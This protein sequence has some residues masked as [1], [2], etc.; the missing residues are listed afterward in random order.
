MGY[1][2]LPARQ[3]YWVQRQPNSCLAAHWMGGQFSC[4]K[5]E[6]VW[7]NISLNLLLIDEEFE[8][9]VDVDTNGQF[10]PETEAEQFTVKIVEEDEDNNDDDA[11]HDND[12]DDKSK[13]DDKQDD[14]YDDKGPAPE[15]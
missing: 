12:G 6:Y 11:D 8:N 3:D 7:R 15:E 9:A 10:K 4:D 2:R 1:C 5:F 14:F 13:K